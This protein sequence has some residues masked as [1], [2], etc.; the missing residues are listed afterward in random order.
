MYK[1]RTSKL[2]DVRTSLVLIMLIS[3]LAAGCTV[4][5]ISDYDQFTDQLAQEVF[6]GLAK[7]DINAASYESDVKDIGAKIQVLRARAESIEKNEPTIEAVKLLEDNYKIMLDF[8]TQDELQI[9]VETMLQQ[10][11]QI[12]DLEIKKR[13]GED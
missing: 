10:T 5:Y 4:K 12:M 6:E 9:A 11:K 7:L 2:T 3:A 13:R 8:K 1:V